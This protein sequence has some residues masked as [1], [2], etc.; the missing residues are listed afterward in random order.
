MVVQAHSRWSALSRELR[1][2]PVGEALAER[3]VLLRVAPHLI[4]LL[5]FMLPH[6]PHLR[7]GRM[8]RAGSSLRPARRLEGQKQSLPKSF[9]TTV[10]WPRSKCRTR[11]ALRGSCRSSAMGFVYSDAQ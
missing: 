7:P 8:L 9:A 1:V 2:P 5:Q 10:A 11:H 4:R 6:E 3:E